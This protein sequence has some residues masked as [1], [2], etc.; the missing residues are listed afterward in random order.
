MILAHGIPSEDKLLKAYV[1]IPWQKLYAAQKEY[2][3]T[4][5]PLLRTARPPFEQPP[6]NYIGKKAEKI[7]EQYASGIPVRQIAKS[8][9][10]STMTVYR[11]VDRAGLRK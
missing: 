9:G 10:I 6:K 3:E 7:L 1:N 5:R 2:G 11:H 4:V 8:L